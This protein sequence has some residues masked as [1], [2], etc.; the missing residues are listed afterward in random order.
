M[1]ENTIT[2]DNSSD[3]MIPLINNSHKLISNKLNNSENSSSSWST[4]SSEN[5]D[6]SKNQQKIA[7]GKRKKSFEKLKISDNQFPKINEILNSSENN[8]KRKSSCMKESKPLILEEEENEKKVEISK[9]KEE[10]SNNLI[11]IKD[12]EKKEY[13]NQKKNEL[14]DEKNYNIKS[15]T[16]IN[17]DLSINISH[18]EGIKKKEEKAKLIIKH[19]LMEKINFSIEKFESQKI[20]FKNIGNTCYMNSFLQILLHTPGFLK[21]LNKERKENLD[22][23]DNLIRLSE[24][25]YNINYLENI[26]QIMGQ[27]KESYGKKNYQSD[28]QEFGI[29][30]INEIITLIKGES[31]FSEENDIEEEQ[32]TSKNVG[33]IKQSKFEKYIDKYYG[34]KNE[35]SLEKMFQFHE[36]KLEIESKENN[37]IIKIKKI[38]FETSVNI[39]LGFRKY[40]KMDLMELLES[41]YNNYLINRN[42]NDIHLIINYKNNDLNENK[43]LKKDEKKKDNNKKINQKSCFEKF[44]EIIKYLDCFGIL[45]CLKENKKKIEEEEDINNDEE[46]KEDYINLIKLASLPKILIISINR[47]FLGKDFNDNIISYEERLDVKKFIDRDI[48]KEEKTNY[49]LYAVNECVAHKKESGHYYSYIKINNETWYKFNDN[50]VIKESP[51]L[52]S[53]YVVGLYYIKDE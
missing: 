26:K 12:N 20:G 29:D 13:K 44:I 33:S 43:N 15:K 34:E 16:Q 2:K 23:I 21:E 46:N 7:V 50:N 37:E 6:K 38:R 25:P 42:N 35:I 5:R 17:N 52:S 30:L 48:L 39:E 31:S 24:D 11:I 4:N 18:S 53:E 8:N 3:K 36:S 45:E 41:K 10:I 51:N 47:A 32:I 19:P 9:K 40:Q 27:I 1:M 14:F 22:L 49:R 28:S